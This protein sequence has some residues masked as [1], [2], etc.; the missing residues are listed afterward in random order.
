[1]KQDQTLESGDG[2]CSND[3]FFIHIWTASIS[4]Q[5][6]G[7]KRSS[8][9]WNMSKLPLFFLRPPSI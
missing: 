1:M 8:G 4:L 6:I 9:G 5:K 2:K 7:F 3:P